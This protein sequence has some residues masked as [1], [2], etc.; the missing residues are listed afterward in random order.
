VKNE[1]EREVLYKQV[2]EGKEKD[3]RARLE[4]VPVGV[5]K[6]SRPKIRSNNA[7]N[8]TAL[9]PPAI[10]STRGAHLRRGLSS[11]TP[12]ATVDGNGTCARSSLRFLLL[13]LPDD[14]V[15]AMIGGGNAVGAGSSSVDGMGVGSTPLFV[16]QVRQI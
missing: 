8:T 6:L 3:M 2:K 13:A 14:L 10:T 7:L 1:T 12:S 5:I 15:F 11:C 16:N 4:I 9:R